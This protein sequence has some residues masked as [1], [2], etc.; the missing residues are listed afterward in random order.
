MRDPEYREEGR[1]EDLLQ[2][3]G[4]ETQDIQYKKFAVYGAYY[5]GFFFMCILL[6]F[7]FVYFMSPTKLQG[8]RMADFV[9]KTT[10]PTSTPFLQSNITSRT[11]IMSLRR[12][13][14]EI[15]TTSGP[16]DQ[17]KGI[18]RIPIENA[19]DIIAQRG[20]PKTPPM[21]TGGTAPAANGGQTVSSVNSPAVR[22]DSATSSS[23]LGGN[24]G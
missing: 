2:E 19:I 13:E 5:F 21:Q 6:G 23:N 12:N 10:A 4:Y 22:G 8:G 24:G 1:P 20:L 14:T 16:V 3:L 18:Y 15:L 9:P 11:D 17:A 7:V